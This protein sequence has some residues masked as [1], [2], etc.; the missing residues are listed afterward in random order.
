MPGMYCANSAGRG[1][2]WTSVSTTR[3]AT[4]SVLGT[5]SCVSIMVMTVRAS[6]L[7]LRSL[8]GLLQAVELGGVAIEDLVA[9]LLG[10][11]GRQR[12]RIAGVPVRVA[13]PE[14]EHVFLAGHREPLGGH[15]RVARTVQGTLDEVHVPGQVVAGDLRSPRGLL[16]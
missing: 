8:D 5:R 11:V 13:G 16:E 1:T 10:P 3:T 4:R 6:L 7:R 9:L 2:G 12:V 15:G 14:H